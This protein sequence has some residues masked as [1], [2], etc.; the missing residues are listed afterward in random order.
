MPQL[1]MNW[2][3]S[4]SCL[5]RKANQYCL[6][7]LKTMVH[8]QTGQSPCSKSFS[9]LVASFHFSIDHFMGKGEKKIKRER[10]RERG[11][12]RWGGVGQGSSEKERENVRNEKVRLKKLFL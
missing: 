10:E 7:S 5:S 3:E 12:E 2:D 1:F 6:I 4:G 9:C 11:R 8:L